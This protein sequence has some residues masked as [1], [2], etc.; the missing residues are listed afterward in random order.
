MS[1]P[2]KKKPNIRNLEKVAKAQ[3]KNE[4]FRKIRKVFDALGYGHLYSLIPP[5]ELDIIYGVRCQAINISVAENDFMPPGKLKWIK[6]IVSSMLKR[7]EVQ[8]VA[9][10]NRIDL[11]TFFTAGITLILY[12][13][14]IEDNFF[15]DARTV[16]DALS[17]FGDNDR[18]LNEA[19]KHLKHISL[20]TGLML[21]DFTRRVYWS[22]TDLQMAQNDANVCY[23]MVW[24][25]AIPDKNYFNIRGE[26]HVGYRVG[27]PVYQKGPK[28]QS[29]AAGAHELPVKH[30]EKEIQIYIQD[31][32]L[33]RL[34]ERNDCVSRESILMEL[35]RSLENPKMNYNQKT[36][37]I[38]ID[39]Y[40]YNV[41]TGYL[42]AN[43]IGNTLLIRTFLFI[44]HI[45]SPEGDILR[46]NTGLKRKEIEFLELDK[47][48]TFM[49][50]EIQENKHIKHLFIEAGCRSLFSL[51]KILLE[52]N[53][54]ISKHPNTAMLEDYLGID[55]TKEYLEEEEEDES[56]IEEEIEE[57]DEVLEEEQ[58]EESDIIEE[59]KPDPRSIYQLY[60][61]NTKLSRKILVWIIM[62]LIGIPFLLIAPFTYPIY[63]YKLKRKKK[64]ENAA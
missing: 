62:I 36:E 27:L 58:V 9:G 64:K 56:I 44:T 8:L 53:I 38:L 42:L 54:T 7:Y 45:G 23:Q 3:H 26:K 55:L 17:V 29:I 31:H 60:P 46:K 5:D 28:W 32:A 4:Y 30:H 51:Y 39:F 61:K 47:L 48:S 40:L 11:D 50:P 6:R 24:H 25:S 63:R 20:T 22:V 15:R 43:V 33:R 52:K 59:S 14:S 21:S 57:D 37:K 12:Q 49:T 34:T 41:K 16:R 10:G 1:K 18:Y 13:R 2:K 19:F 35:I